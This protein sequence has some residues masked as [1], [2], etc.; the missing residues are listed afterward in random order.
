MSNGRTLA[1]GSNLDVNPI[2]LPVADF[3][4]LPD[5]SLLS[6]SLSCMGIKCDY[7]SHFLIPFGQ[8]QLV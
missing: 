3:S 5:L 7:F 1:L 8:G 6:A 4:W 2:S